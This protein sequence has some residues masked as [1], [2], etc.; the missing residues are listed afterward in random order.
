MCQSK[1][2]Y[3]LNLNGR[4]CQLDAT[5]VMGIVNVTPDSFYADSRVEAGDALLAKIAQH[6]QE[7]ASIIDVGACSTRPGSEA[8]SAREEMQRL[9]PALE[10]IRRHY[11]DLLLSVDTFRAEVARMAVEEFAVAIINDVSGGDADADMFRTVAECGVP[12]VLTH[13]ASCYKPASDESSDESIEDMI[14]SLAIKLAELRA[15]GVA[16]VLIDPGFGFGKSL[17]DNYRLLRRLAD[18]RVLDAPILV[19]VSRKS[20]AYKLL[21]IKPEEALNATSVLHTLALQS[22]VEILRV[23]DVKAAVECVKLVDYYQS[24]I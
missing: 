23:H 15:L 1:K 9:R 6:L 4:L 21:D 13:S 8:V 17:E 24:V 14:R 16:D 18:F 3:S 22:G 2:V 20:M 5:L 12:Y 19:G 10:L 11:P 7:G